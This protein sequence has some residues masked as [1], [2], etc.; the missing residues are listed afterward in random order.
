MHSMQTCNKQQQQQRATND[1]NNNKML[2]CLLAHF[3]VSQRCRNFYAFF[4]HLL[5]LYS[6]SLPYSFAS[7]FPFCL[8]CFPIFF[9]VHFYFILFTFS[10]CPA[11]NHGRWVTTIAITTMSND[12]D[13]AGAIVGLNLNPT[14]P[15][16]PPSLAHN[17]RYASFGCFKSV[18]STS[19]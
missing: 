13:N 10:I 1:S 16:V 7:S 19:L 8:F 15:P 2:H 9:V 12:S 17:N 3:E 14:K 11:E 18:C 6:P 5:Q 4:R